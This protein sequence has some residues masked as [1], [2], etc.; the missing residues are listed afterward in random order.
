MDS[1]QDYLDEIEDL[2]DQ[3]KSVPFSNRVSV[4]RERIFELIGEIRMNLPSEINQAQRIID[5]HDRIVNEAKTKGAGILRDYENEAKT[6]VNSHEIFK[7]ANEQ[8]NEFIEETKQN[9]RE[10]KLGA[11]DYADDV[12]EKSESMIREAMEN[13]EQQYKYLMDFF[14][15]TLEVLYENRQQL[16]GN[17]R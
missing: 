12:L 13:I 2:L 7:R 9:A 5:D 11:V 4:D 1:L 10:M 3:S 14:N 17:L 8:A 15:E 6:L 16:R